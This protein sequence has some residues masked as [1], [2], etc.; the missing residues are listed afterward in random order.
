MV[1]VGHAG[2]DCGERVDK[3]H[4]PD[5]MPGSWRRPIYP[6]GVRGQEVERPEK[7]RALS[8]RTSVVRLWDTWEFGPWK[9]AEN[10]QRSGSPDSRTCVRPWYG[11][12]SVRFRF[13]TQCSNV[14][15]Q[16]VRTRERCSFV[17]FGDW[18][19][20]GWLKISRV[21]SSREKPRV[22]EVR[23][24]FGRGHVVRETKARRRF[25]GGA[26]RVSRLAV[27]VE[28]RCRL[29]SRLVCERAS[30]TA[31]RD[32]RRRASHSSE[33]SRR[34]TASVACAVAFPSLAH[35]SPRLRAFLV[36]PRLR[37]LS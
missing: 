34:P 23:S 10:V 26:E 11:S 31:Q 37:R 32:A 27:R 20:N 8:V 35:V 14:R 21:A 5:M 33:S 12:T 24:R 7:S 29:G 16:N 25:L 15:P 22:V 19:L 4:R 17:D 18:K 30:F 1:H 6:R 9:K 3:P 2:A 36:S 28:S 13:R